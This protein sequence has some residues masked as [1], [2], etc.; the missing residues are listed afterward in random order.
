MAP[1]SA[2][3]VSRQF[4]AALPVIGVLRT[5]VRYGHYLEVTAT[6]TT[7]AGLERAPAV[8]RCKTAG[9]RAEHPRHLPH[10]GRAIRHNRTGGAAVTRSLLAHEP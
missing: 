5:E 10:P 9:Y 1:A 2:D 6:G 4:N 8:I 3:L 7:T